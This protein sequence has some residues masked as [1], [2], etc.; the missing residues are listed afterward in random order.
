MSVFSI[1][2]FVS[3]S[4]STLYFDNLTTEN[5]LNDNYVNC[6]K[7][8]NEG[9]I[10]I[11]TAMGIQK[12][13]GV[14]FKHYPLY[15]NDSTYI[16]NFLNRNF[17]QSKK[18]DLY[19]CVEDYGLFIYNKQADKFERLK[20]NGTPVLTESSVKHVIEDKKGN[21]WVATKDGVNYVD[22][23]KQEINTLKHQPG[24]VNSLF[25]NYVRVLQLEDSTKLWIG[26]Q[27]GVDLYNLTNHHFTHFAVQNP[28]LDDDIN[29]L[30]VDKDG[31]KWVATGGHGIVQIHPDNSITTFFYDKEDSRSNTIRCFLRDDKD[32]FWFGTRGGLF[33]YDK[34]GK[35]HRYH[36]NLLE[37]KSLVHNSIMRISQDDKGDIWVAT[38]GGLGHLVQE[39]QAFTTFKAMPDNSHY[40][41][42]KE[43]Y[44]FYEDPSGSIWMGTEN[45]GVN[46]FNPV[47]GEFTYLTVENGKISNN[48][49]KSI[50]GLP[51]G[52]VLIG[53]FQGGLN[54]YD[55]T[56]RKTKIFRYNTGNPQ[57]ISDDIVWSIC[58][59]GKGRIWLGT[60]A[61]LDLFDPVK[62]TFTHFPEFDD[63]VNGVNWIGVDRD[64]DLWLGSEQIKIFRPG[65]GVMNTFTEKSRGFYEDSQLNTWITTIDKGVVRYDKRKGALQNFT[66]EEG[67]SSNLTYCMEEDSNGKLWI[68]TADGLSCFNP[69]DT[70]FCNYYRADGLLADQFHYG[71]SLKAVNGDLLF[72]GINGF[73]R[74]H[75]SDIAQNQYIPPVQ[76]TN[77]RVDNVPVSP[78]NGSTIN[79]PHT[80]K[81]LTFDFVALNYANSAQNQY[82]YMLEGFDNIWNE[83]TTERSA[84]YTNLSPGKYTFKVLGSNNQGKW[85][86]NGASRILI[87]EPPFYKTP[88][89]YVLLTLILLVLITVSY[90]L[91]LRALAT[92]K[93]HEFEKKEA[94]R[95]HESDLSKLQFFTNISHEIKTPLTLIIS[96][97]EKIIKE[98]LPKKELQPYL[99]LM[100]RNARQ[101]MEMVTQLLDYRKLE[102]GKLQVETS[103]GDMVRFVK[104]QFF[105]FGE[106]MKDQGI[107]YSFKSVQDEL[108]TDFDHDKVRKILDNLVSNAIKYN[109]PQ[110]SVFVTLSLVV[111]DFED[112]ADVDQFIQITVKDTGVGISETGL[113]EIFKRFYTGKHQNST[114]SGIGLSFTEDLV[115]LLGGKITVESVEHQGTA[116]TV[117]LPLQ[118]QNQ[119]GVT[120]VNETVTNEEIHKVEE[121]ELS[122]NDKKSG[123]PLLLIVE[124]NRDVRE[125]LHAQF[126]KNYQV[127][128]AVNGQQGWDLAVKLIPDLIISDVMMP[129]LQ[130]N[131]L[132]ER[133]KKDV[134]TSHIP[135]ILLTALSSK[136]DELEGLIKGADDYIAKPFDMAILQTKVENLL[137]IR[138]SLRI[139]FMQE[140]V[141]KPKNVK[142]ESLDEKFLQKAIEVVEQHIDN[143]DL[144]ITIFGQELGISR[145]QLYRKMDAL[146]KMTVK[147]FINDIRLKRAYQLLTESELTV[148]EV[149]YAVGF[150]NISYF[151]RCIRKKYGKSASEIIKEERK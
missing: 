89:F 16:K 4:G 64:N 123:K 140:M 104:E 83:P 110:G 111:N 57:G 117:Y 7:Q 25:D 85:N 146:T 29:D 105:G 12:F 113:K 31:V 143:P 84:T 26:T 112:I 147:E 80:S 102:S 97:L 74:F 30:Y 66:E 21:F 91:I 81:V 10:W 58:K 76:I 9:W 24:K 92:R 62:E 53:T 90:I 11:G 86:L 114:S 149:G 49:I 139:K 132:C 69:T 70:S 73:V 33:K 106:L 98:D 136:K 36:N 96:P 135:V 122:E 61:G 134:R 115:K 47:K 75:P 15:L 23:K 137:A 18:G 100:H 55:P 151:G 19:S 145:M 59:D 3:V 40:L 60:G 35:I 6:V 32:N 109:K 116:F 142:V 37:E 150:N 119:E 120:S 107:S 94:V 103:K 20:L 79:V 39:K 121:V 27:S 99:K 45:G 148:S 124:D 67:L 2:H 8:D 41:N 108:I 65:Y 71:A 118:P 43:V 46:I 52:K 131:E 93:T 50:Q 141:L 101:L 34:N 54:V 14:A 88:L 95:Q 72:G 17:Y 77:I 44:C 130:G 22:F 138:E 87:I 42:N 63:M 56:T 127:Q 48:C 38:R 1:I 129:E 51:N 125:F 144:D 82:R 78:L 68:S 128:E 13:D 133:I 5:G 28:V 126:Q